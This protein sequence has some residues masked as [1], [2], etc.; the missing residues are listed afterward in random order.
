MVIKGDFIFYPDVRFLVV[1]MKRRIDSVGFDCD[2]VI[3]DTHNSRMP[4]IMQAGERMGLVIPPEKIG[5][6]YDESDMFTLFPG[7]DRGHFSEIYRSLDAVYSAVHGAKEVLAFLE[8]YGMRKWMF[9]SRYAV[10]LQKRMNQVE[11]DLAQFHP[12]VTAETVSHRAKTDQ[13]AFEICTENLLQAGLDPSRALYIDDSLASYMT[14]KAVGFNMV[15]LPHG[16]KSRGYETLVPPE[17]I[18]PSMTELP[19]FLSR[20]GYDLS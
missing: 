16:P 18:L 4:R 3:L 13:V 19:D 6:I 11:I 2:D 12:V 15:L 20:R 17:D 9:T 1:A 8:G 7:L 10:D 14:G 5:D